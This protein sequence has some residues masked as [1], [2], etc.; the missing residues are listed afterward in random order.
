LIEAQAARVPVVTTLSGG[1]ETAVIDGITGRIVVP[2]AG[3]LADAVAQLL[4]DPRLAARYAHAGRDH[5][6]ASFSVERLVND[7][8]RLYTRLLASRE[9]PG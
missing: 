7:I 8:D 5:A 1:V 9:R 6:L 3:A 4:D 2:D